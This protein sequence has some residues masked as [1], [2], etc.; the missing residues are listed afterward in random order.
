MCKYLVKMSEI[1]GMYW[2]VEGQRS[3]CLSWRCVQRGTEETAKWL[4]DAN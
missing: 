2:G 3:N 4:S 1:L